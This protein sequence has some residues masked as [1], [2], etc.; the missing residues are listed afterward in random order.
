MNTPN[1]WTINSRAPVRISDF[2]GWTDTWF[3]RYGRV[4]NLAVEPAVQV[5]IAVCDDGQG[6]I[7]IYAENYEQRYEYRPGGGW[8]RHP[9]LEGCIEMA[10]VQPGLSL[11]INVYS[12]VQPG[13]AAGTSAAVAVALLGALHEVSPAGRKGPYEIAMEALRVETEL[14]HGQSGIQ[15]QLSAAYGGINDIH[16]FDYPQAAVAPVR[17]PEA[18]WLAL[19]RRLALVYFGRPHDSYRLHRLVIQALED[20]GP[21]CA[22]LNDLRAIAGQARDALYAGDWPALGNAMI[23]N[24]EAQARLHPALVGEAAGQVIEVARRH[25]A[26][27]WKVNG[28]GGDGGSLTLLAGERASAKRAMLAAIAAES[29]E[30]EIIPIRLNREGLLVWREDKLDGEKS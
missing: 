23:A 20:A 22:Q 7:E 5:Q 4:V 16:M 14:L 25:G 9:L 27:G 19:E 17:I 8:V 11:E 26:L 3:A 6:R 12:P 2:G 29:P 10:G 18:N 21:D 13:A 24:T 28:A 15:D 30:F 1:R